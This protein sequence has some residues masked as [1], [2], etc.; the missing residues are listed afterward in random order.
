MKCGKC[1]FDNPPGM[2]FCG[3]CGTKLEMVC[4]NCKAPNSPDYK[5]CGE[6]KHN[7]SSPAVTALPKDVSFDEKLAKIW[8]Y[9]PGSLTDTT[10]LTGLLFFF[11]GAS[12]LV[13]QVAWQ[14]MLTLQ[15]GVG[16][17]S[18]AM[19]VAAYMAGL[20]I[21]SHF[22]GMLCAH[23]SK[24]KALMAFAFLECGIGIWGC[25]SS[26]LY[27]DL[28][29]LPQAWFLPSSWWVGFAHF[30][31]LL[32]PTCLM[33]MSLPLLVHSRVQDSHTACRT[34]GFLYG[35]NTLGAA[36]GSMLTPWLLIRQLG[37]GGAVLAA[38][39]VNVSVGVSALVLGSVDQPSSNEKQRIMRF[40]TGGKLE[41]D[42]SSHKS[43]V[44]WTALYAL[45]G[46]CAI[47][48]EILWF[49]IM[50][51]AIKSTAFTYGTIL[52]SFLT[53]LALGSLFAVP[54]ATRI[55]RPLM[56]FLLC[57]CLLI[58]VSGF[59]IVML[60]KLPLETWGYR[61]LVLFWSQR[62]P[63]SVGDATT[64][65][66]AAFYVALPILL[67]AIP[68]FL[69]GVSFTALQAA[70][71]DDP[72]TS[73]KKVGILQ[74]ANIVGC[75]AGSLVMGLLGLTFLGTTGSLRT[76]VGLS[77]IF[78]L[79]GTWYYGLKRGF[80][81]LACLT[82]LLV[83]MIPTQDSFW[84]RLHGEP[85]SEA[86]FA[87]DCSG[88]VA[89]TVERQGHYRLSVNGVA[90]SYV[91][92]HPTHTMLGALPA[93]VHPS[94]RKV[95]VIGLGSGSTAWAASCRPETERVEVFELVTGEHILINR[96]AE[97]YQYPRLSSFL[98]DPRLRLTIADGRSSL[99]FSD[100]L[101][102][103]IEADPIL[104][105]T[106]YSGQLYS[107]EFFKLCSSRLLPDGI[108]CQWDST[109]RVRE[110]FASVFPY[111][112]SF[113]HVLIGSKQPIPID[114]ATWQARLDSTAVQDYLGK[115]DATRIRHHL[116]FC[117]KIR[118]HGRSHERNHD[119]FPRDE[120]GVSGNAN[121]SLLRGFLR[122]ANDGS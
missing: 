13:Y 102:D 65:F 14:R 42:G 105:I 10:L 21:G 97:E 5:F 89:L 87:E 19:I 69:M 86:L 70:V 40:P 78:A 1:Q 109:S 47:G 83:V 3:Q 93:V 88:V 110:T 61:H 96:L 80:A 58:I 35:V 94:P 75:T 72:R 43:L 51:V 101:Y 53:S 108:M 62:F 92:F 57:Q 91:P 84:R 71:H 90:Q 2:K 79:T 25:F 106:A 73:G 111:V 63:I 26:R 107:T 38:A 98:K 32:V 116:G 122:W 16:V 60:V 66:L 7:L 77:L 118:A 49:R 67:C 104:P 36:V 54:V 100:R 120:F 22:G 37:I 115:D 9:L 45:S 44:L 27:V 17:Y 95:L 85:K 24:Q 8:K 99:R 6:R 103:L 33:G 59:V 55:R 56:V 39:A 18:V 74:A 50:D 112:L 64:K 52:A 82:I 34:V 28:L 117:Q 68:T 15:S 31:L 4:P 76:L 11:S 29:F 119:L 46:F 114:V 20:G 12:A 113:E 41:T 48:L 23:L 81:L 30:A 121:S